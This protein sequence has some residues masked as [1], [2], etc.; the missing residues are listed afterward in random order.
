MYYLIHIDDDGRISIKQYEKDVLLD[1]I[2]DRDYG[3]MTFMDSLDEDA[4]DPHEWGFG[5]AN[6][7]IIKGEI[8]TPKPVEVVTEYE[9]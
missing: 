1:A 4:T 6:S 5:G 8:V 3:E 7:L 2:K 9:L